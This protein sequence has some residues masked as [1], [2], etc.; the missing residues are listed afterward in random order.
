MRGPEGERAVE[1]ILDTG[2]DGWLSLPEALVRIL[3]LERVRS[4]RAAL[5]DGTEV[6]LDVYDAE[7]E[8]HGGWRRIAVDEAD[9][10]PLVGM[11]LLRGS[12]V[13]PDVTEGGHVEILP[14]SE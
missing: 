14:L 8:W 2:F 5:A 11:R 6:D 12:S 13:C 7:V 3:G 10:D 4:S 1:A 9:T